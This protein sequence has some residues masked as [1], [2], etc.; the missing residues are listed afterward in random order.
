M[1]GNENEF[2]SSQMTGKFFYSPNE[3]RAFFFYGTVSLFTSRQL[4]AGIQNGMLMPALVFLTQNYSY[5]FFACVT[6]HK[7]GFRVVWARQDG[8]FGESYLQRIEGRLFRLVPL[9]TCR[10]VFFQRVCKW[11][12][13]LRETLDIVLVVAYHP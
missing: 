9:Y 11:A 10:S 1:I 7:K 6:L 4:S 12:S 8:L 2:R 3:A 5:P 13:N